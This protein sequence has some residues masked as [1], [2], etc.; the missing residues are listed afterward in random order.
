MNNFDRVITYAKDCFGNDKVDEFFQKYSINCIKQCNPVKSYLDIKMLYAA[1][2]LSMYFNI[3]EFVTVCGEQLKTF[4]EFK[5]RYGTCIEQI[6]EKCLLF[7]ITSF[8]ESNNTK[9]LSYNKTG[10]DHKMPHCSY[11][12]T[13]TEI[14]NI[15]YIHNF[16]IHSGP[17]VIR[18]YPK[19]AV[20]RYN[21]PI[22]GRPRV[23]LNITFDDYN[24]NY[25]TT[26][27][28]GILLNPKNKENRKAIN[29]IQAIVYCI[30]NGQCIPYV[31]RMQIP[32]YLK[33]FKHCD[34]FGATDF[35]RRYSAEIFDYVHS[36]TNE[37]IF[38]IN[39]IYAALD[40]N[41]FRIFI[42]D[43]IPEYQCTCEEVNI[44]KFIRFILR[45]LFLALNA[46][47]SL[48]ESPQSEAF[49]LR[50][51]MPECLNAIQK[52]LPQFCLEKLSSPTMRSL[53]KD[54]P[55]LTESKNFRL[56][57]IDNAYERKRHIWNNQSSIVIKTS[58][59]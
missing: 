56:K 20:I 57:Q 37:D 59:D 8:T 9:L 54:L 10:L 58:I 21:N 3:N 49:I 18:L 50:I 45:K 2:R 24:I 28:A 42:S 46:R 26:C 13:S 34:Y 55:L 40:T 41:T 7:D 27:G 48:K 6:W 43:C 4:Y 16:I 30:T 51:I 47:L 32:F 36:L 5:K 12:A 31:E 38:S 15:Y 52:A 1:Y 44:P 14:D 23:V 29:D 35:Y 11:M 33:K 17:F 39:E 22:N 25:K 19:N 53:Y